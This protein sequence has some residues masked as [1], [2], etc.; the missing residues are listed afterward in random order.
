MNTADINKVKWTVAC[1]GE[2]A[3]HKSVDVLAAFRY[4]Y[5]F[6]GIMFLKEHYEAEHTL[7]FDETVEDLEL[8]CAKNGGRL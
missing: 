4:L 8:I 5:E 3:R 6:G 1:I 7:S 2:F